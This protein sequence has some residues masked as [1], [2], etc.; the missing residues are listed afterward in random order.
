MLVEASQAKRRVRT[1]LFASL[2]RRFEA[3][4]RAKWSASKPGPDASPATGPF[5]TSR[6]VQQ[7][8]NFETLTLAQKQV[9]SLVVKQRQLLAL[10]ASEC[11]F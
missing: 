9:V 4:C 5:S 1:H 2:A 3:T 8:P 7:R 10:R 6:V 11:Q